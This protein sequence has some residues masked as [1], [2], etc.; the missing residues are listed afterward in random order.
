MGKISAWAADKVDTE[1][2][3]LTK[4]KSGAMKARLL[5]VC[6]VEISLSHMVSLTYGNFFLYSARIGRMDQPSS[7]HLNQVEEV[8][9]GIINK[10]YQALVHL[11][12]KNPRICIFLAQNVNTT[13]HTQKGDKTTREK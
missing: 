9:G 4:M 7:I 11:P 1:V 10:E 3:R 2:T 8:Q 6:V 5:H 13:N 12:N